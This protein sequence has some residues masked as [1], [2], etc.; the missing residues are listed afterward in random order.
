MARQRRRRL[1]RFLREGFPATAR[2]R[3][4][5]VEDSA[6]GQTMLK[7]SY[8]YEAD[9]AVRR[10]ADTLLPAI[11]DRWRDGDLIQVLYLPG[12]YDS[13]IVSTE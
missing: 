6:F 3:G 12:V 5:R 10:D 2:V 13:V 7:V 4:T 9:G 1:V 11:G 8:E